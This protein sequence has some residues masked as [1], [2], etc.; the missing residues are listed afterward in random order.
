MHNNIEIPE[1][2]TGFIKQPVGML[3][4]SKIETTSDHSITLSNLKDVM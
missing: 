4:T 1:W 3:F 2:I